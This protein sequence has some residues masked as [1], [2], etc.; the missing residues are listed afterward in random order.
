MT[1]ATP[2]MAELLG[3]SPAMAS[4]RERVARLLGRQAEAGRL[5]PILIEG[6][7]GTGKGLLA[8]LIHRRSIRAAAPFV[9]INCAAIPENLLEAELF[10][11][12]RGAFTD[13]RHA[14]PGLF[15]AAHRG[16]LFLD[17]VGLLPDLVQGKVLKV[18]E[19]HVIRRLGSV[20]A[21]PTDIWIIA[22]TSDDL[23]SSTR[24]R[25]FREDLYHR[26]AAL[27]LRLP[28][29]RERGDDV[30]LLAEHF[31][32]RACTDYRLPTKTLDGGARQ[33]LLHYP[34]PG[35]VRELT[36]VMERVALL[37][38][39]RCVTATALDLLSRASAAH[40]DDE[41]TELPPLRA[42]V[43]DVE[44][45]RIVQILTETG[46]NIS[47]A[48]ARLGIPRSSLRY[49]LEKYGLQPSGAG[50]L[51]PDAVVRPV[52]AADPRETAAGPGVRPIDWQD[53]HLALLQI[54]L[55]SDADREPSSRAQRLMDTILGKVQSL[56]GRVEEQGEAGFVAVFGLE[57]VED[58]CTRAAH[59]ALAIQNAAQ[60]GRDTDP[61]TPALTCALHAG[62]LL[63]GNAGAR[64]V[65]D[66]HAR[67]R[68][69]AVLEALS[70]GA[71]DGTILVSEAAAPLLERRFQLE[72]VSGPR[73]GAA[74]VYRVVA[75]EPTGYGLAGRPLTPF[76][77]RASEIALLDGVR[78]RVTAGHG[79]VVALV[80]E[81]G[82]GKSRITYEL[83]RAASER[84]WVALEGHAASYGAATPYLPLIDLLRRYFRLD[85]A[86]RPRAVHDKIR[87]RLAALP[88]QGLATTVPA[89][90]AVLG[91]PTEDDEWLRLDP[92]QRRERILDGVKRVL[93]RESQVQPLLVLFEDL[94]WID[95]ETQAVLDRLV[96]SLP[97][98]RVLLLVNCRPEYKHGW[99]S[100]TYY[101][102]LQIDPLPP[103]SSEA[104]LDALLGSDTA[105]GPVKRLVIERTEGNPFFIEE[106]V[107]SL[108]ETGVLAGERGAYRLTGV[109]QGLHVPATAQ[110]MLAARI[111]RLAPED[112]R[113]LQVASVVG[114]EVPFALL[115]GIADL[116]DE[117]LR[118]GLDRL[119]AAEFLY[120]TGLYPDLEYCFKHALT[121]EVT[122][123]GLLHARRRELHARIVDAIETLHRERLGEQV[124]RLAHHA[125]RG[126]LREKAV[127]YLRQAGLKAAARSAPQD[128]RA[129]FEQALSVLE[130]LP[131]SQSTLE[132]AF[133]IRLELRPVMQ[134]LGEA[135]R[136]LE[137]L[138]EAEALAERLNDDGRRG[139][140]CA[141]ATNDHSRLEELD[142]ALVTGGRALEIAGRLGDVRLRILTTSF[143]GQTHYY[144]GEYERAV[145]LAIDNLAALP[146]DWVYEYFGNSA[147]ASVYD[148]ACLVRSLAE[149]GR[150]GEAATY[151]AEAIRI[152]ESTQHAF[153][154]AAAHWAAGTLHLLKGDWAKARSL[155]EHEIAV[156]RAG[157]LVFLL[158]FAVAAS[159]WV[160]A[161]LGEAS[162]ALNRLRE[163]D[164]LFER[165]AADGRIAHR[166]WVY[167]SLGRAS[168]LLGRLDEARCLADRAVE[169]A[170]SQ[171]GFAAHA[172]HLLGDI[173][174]HPDGFDAPRGEA[175]YH[176]ALALAEPG[177]MRPLIAHCHLG[178]GK[179]Y[180]RTDKREQAQ[181]YLT[182]AT[183]MYREM[184]MT[185]WL[186]RA[187]ATIRE[188]V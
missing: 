183:M 35:N 97:T 9:D 176:E 161:Q 181:M 52:D 49:R 185:Y 58:A 64:V 162:E 128:A 175:H 6:E 4:I 180:R 76:V 14:K 44:R 82:V 96:E 57:P 17:E 100:K 152:A 7:T 41:R 40:P 118:R 154:I 95:T 62:Y 61:L 101:R 188:S 47:R 71:A 121:H 80:G 113:L 122:Y 8:R 98:A 63:A 140:V 81:P 90:L 163:G 85:D 11:F 106:S 107:C 20:Q 1:S 25:R 38:D 105:L 156:V 73:A 135:R 78:A 132:Q 155:I 74:R 147:P 34:W 114:R 92:P 115:E 116:P 48:A 179:L 149:L 53:R 15:Q 77:G 144:R 168:L 136:M 16:V 33:A 102:Q 137:R 68:A 54:T 165:I 5:P 36:N 186:E 148:R 119:Q 173:A 59:A 84:G 112:K 87:G 91:G 125:L 117:A 130:A 75:R 67:H 170:P 153:T 37:S 12:E 104:L 146:A 72:P 103:E 129:S 45:R 109:V 110:A 124:E 142:E 138:R 19:E 141:L 69:H 139:R 31:L 26:L 171:R 145:G 18:I 184:G 66:M 94:H 46:W 158:P 22:A 10:G 167:H 55:A 160:L 21:D 51:P 89:L 86:D 169:T 70:R 42:A 172:R 65:I 126:E 111:D 182:T 43:G 60:R 174:A 3:Q 151:E 30:T 28:P 24:A 131:E 157:S 134:Q 133:E 13:A 27:T 99:G 88:D 120:E 39:D 93:L 123:S 29:L 2:S 56:G 23:L 79:Q 150:F 187:E 178:L 32:T 166:T 108:V 50:P 159:A 164:Q 127:D 143:L 177:G 83:A